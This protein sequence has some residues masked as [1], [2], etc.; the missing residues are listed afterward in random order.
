VW[1]FY[2]T[3]NIE[4]LSAVMEAEHADPDRFTVTYQSTN[5]KQIT[6]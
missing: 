1:L 5:K 6:Y 4:A 3:V 2:G